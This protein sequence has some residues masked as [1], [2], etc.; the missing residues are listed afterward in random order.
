M[1][2]E[3]GWRVGDVA[4]RAGIAVSAIHFYEAQGFIFSWRDSGNQRRFDPS[5]LRRIA[6]IK[7]AQKLGISLK[8]IGDALSV[9]PRNSA[10]S[11][12]D[13]TLM[14]TQWRAQLEDKIAQL[15]QLKDD[16]DQCIGCG[17][18]SMKTC[19]LRNPEDIVAEQGTGA[20]FWNQSQQP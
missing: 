12:A 16:L 7:S 8:E 3:S 1:K 19:K 17:C 15:Q 2:K 13:W 20:V 4:R 11:T 6:V 5:V 9:L 14:S 10:P 18:L